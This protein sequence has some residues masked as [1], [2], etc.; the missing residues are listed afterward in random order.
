MLSQLFLCSLQDGKALG[1]NAVS[2]AYTTRSRP[3][4]ISSASPI[5]YTIRVQGFGA[6]GVAGVAGPYVEDCGVGRLATD[7]CRCVCRAGGGGG[8]G[9][10]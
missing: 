9:G 3:V 8:G 6:A 7:P 1:M 10:R 2:H 5:I 4:G